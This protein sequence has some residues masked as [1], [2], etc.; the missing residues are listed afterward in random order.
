LVKYFTLNLYDNLGNH[1][2]ISTTTG[3][4]EEGIKGS[5]YFTLGDTKT[6]ILPASIAHTVKLSAYASGFFTLDLTELQGDTIIASTTFMGIPT[7]TLSA[8]NFFGEGVDI[9]LY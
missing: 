4:L 9:V 3:Q 2:G 5:T 8:G 6:I 1:T 7:A